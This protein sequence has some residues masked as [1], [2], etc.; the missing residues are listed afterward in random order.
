[1]SSL[2]LLLIIPPAW[3]LQ[4]WIHVSAHAL[5]AK[6]YGAR[7]SVIDFVPRRSAGGC[8]LASIRW[9]EPAEWKA[10]ERALVAVAPLIVNTLLILLA[11]GI[12]F[13]ELHGLVRYAFLLFAL[14]N[15]TDAF[16]NVRRVI[17]VT[18]DDLRTGRSDLL[19]C[20][21]HLRLTPGWLTRAAF[22][23]CFLFFL[24]ATVLW[25]IAV[26]VWIQTA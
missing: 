15:L 18:D 13:V 5:V 26:V 22:F 21:R 16:V 23:W 25:T 24:P 20:G 11:L 10:S 17:E 14:T 1:M 8:R 7:V 9:V 2:L 12:V 6:M 19:R 3:W 4:S